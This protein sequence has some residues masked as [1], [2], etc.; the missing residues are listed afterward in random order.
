MD[1]TCCRS[2]LRRGEAEARITRLELRCWRMGSSRG[3]GPL[4]IGRFGRG[5][6]ALS[7]TLSV[8]GGG[9]LGKLESAIFRGGLQ[10]A[11]PER[12]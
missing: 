3:C 2:A 6:A 1:C 8:Y 12:R 11:T 4:R 5:G 7:S 9:S 10:I